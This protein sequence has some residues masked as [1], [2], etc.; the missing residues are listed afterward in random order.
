V[1]L[2]AEE[3]SVAFYFPTVH[4]DWFAARGIL[5]VSVFAGV[6]GRL[7]FSRSHSVATISDKIIH[8]RL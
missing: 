7:P 1:A 2:C 8:P 5:I 4:A 3:D 6:G